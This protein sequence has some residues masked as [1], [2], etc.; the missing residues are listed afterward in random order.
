MSTEG[1]ESIVFAA[2]LSSGES[3][4]AWLAFAEIQKR[5]ALLFRAGEYPDKGVSITPA[6]LD[7]VVA[8]FHAAAARGERCAVKVEHV[9]TPLD[10]LGDVLGVYHD[11]SGCLYGM[12][13]FSAG[14]AAHLEARRV[15][16]V[17]VALLR[18][19]EE[20]G[21]GFALKEVSVVFSARVPGAGFL[22]AEQ[23]SAKLAEFKAAGKVTPAMEP[24]AAALLAAPGVVTFSDGSQLP[25][26]AEV[27]AL[28]SAL[29]V[30]QPRGGGI[31]GGVVPTEFKAP[32]SAGR[33][34]AALAPEVERMVAGLGAD[35]A[36]IAATLVRTNG[37]GW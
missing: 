1:T 13:G 5:P 22:S 28:L 9:D 25:V 34:A 33:A 30:V 3:A 12:L 8:R 14:I 35:P 21:G 32:G 20:E 15:Q 19:P 36:K 16:D 23:V 7:A 24:H 31:G 29:P 11:G 26:Q 4:S 2:R 6:D 17:S 10:P 27:L 37:K 18:L